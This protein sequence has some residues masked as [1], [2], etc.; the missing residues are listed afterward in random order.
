[1]GKYKEIY[2]KNNNCTYEHSIS[3]ISYL[4]TSYTQIF[5]GVCDCACVGVHFNYE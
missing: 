3:S 4:Y 5:S 1:M 2:I